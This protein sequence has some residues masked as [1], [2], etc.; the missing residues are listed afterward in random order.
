MSARILHKSLNVLA[1]YVSLLTIKTKCGKFGIVMNGARLQRHRCA[2][3]AIDAHWPTLKQW[4][5]EFCLQRQQ[6]VYD[7]VLTS[8][9]VLFSETVQ[10]R[11]NIVQQNKRS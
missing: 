3:S 6:N 2:C 4:R 11:T 5:V 9:I 8:S 10:A 7:Q 1:P